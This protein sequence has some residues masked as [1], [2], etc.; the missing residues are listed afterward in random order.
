[1][2]AKHRMSLFGIFLIVLMSLSDMSIFAATRTFDGGP[3]GT[4][5]E[6][7]TAAN[8]SSDTKPTST[9]DAVI[10]VGFTVQVDEDANVNNLT[11]AGVLEPNGSSSRVMT[12]ERDLTVSAGGEIHYTDSD[13][14]SST[15]RM[16]WVFNGV[17][18]GTN[19][20]NNT[21]GASSDLQFYN[22]T[23]DGDMITTATKGSFYIYGSFTS[24]G[25]NF[26][27]ADGDGIIYF[28]EDA[29]STSQTITP[30][31]ANFT[32]DD[33]Y[34]TGTT[35]SLETNEEINV[36]GN[37]NVA[38]GNSFV[39]TGAALKI[40]AS[41]ASS[42]ITPD[43]TLTFAT[44]S[45]LDIDDACV[46]AGNLP[47]FAGTVDIAASKTFTVAPNY[48]ISGTGSL[49]TAAAS[50]IEIEDGDGVAGVF[51]L[52]GSHSI[53]DAT[54]YIIANGSLGFS[55]LS[56][57]KIDDLYIGDDD[58]DDETVTGTESFT[59]TGGLIIMD[60]ASSGNEFT[61][62]SGTITMSGTSKTI[63]SNG[64]TIDIYALDIA[65]SITS[66]NTTLLTI[67]NFLGTSGSGTFTMDYSAGAT[68]I[69]TFDADATM[70]DRSAS[71][72]SA[73]SIAIGDNNTIV[74]TGTL[75]LASDLYLYQ[76]TTGGISVSAAGVLDFQ[77]NSIEF[78]NHA[79]F[80]TAAAATLKTSI[81]GGF[82]AN[83]L[84]TT[85]SANSVL[86]IDNATDYVYNSGATDLG[87]ELA[88]G[89][90]GAR[91]DITT[92]DDITID[93]AVIIGDY[94][95][96]GTSTLSSSGNFT[97]TSGTFTPTVASDDVLD[98]TGAK[99][100]TNSA[101]SAHDL[102]FGKVL[103]SGTIET[104]GD[105]HF[106]S[107]LADALDVT[108]TLNAN[109]NDSH[110]YFDGAGGV[111]SI[112]GNGGTINFHDLTIS[113]GNAAIDATMT[114]MQ[115]EGDL[116][117]SGTGNLTGAAASDVD[118]SGATAQTI[119]IGANA[120]SLDIVTVS[121]TSGGVTTDDDMT[122]GN[123]AGLVTLSGAGGFIQT[124]GTVTKA[125]TG[126][127]V[128][129]SATF[130]ILSIA[131]ATTV[132]GDHS[133]RKELRGAGT[134]NQTGGTVTFL[135]DATDLDGD[136]D[137]GADGKKQCSVDLSADGLT[138]QPNGVTVPSDVE[139]KISVATA[140]TNTVNFSVDGR[141]ELDAATSV[142][143][144]TGGAMA[145]N[146]GSD[147]H[148]SAGASGMGTLIA[149][150]GTVTLDS[151]ASIIF[152]GTMTDLEMGT[153]PPAYAGTGGSGAAAAG[154]VD[155]IRNIT[156]NA[157]AI[158][159]TADESMTVN[160]NVKNLSVTD[161]GAATAGTFT[162]GG[163]A[164]VTNTGGGDFDF[165]ALEV[166]GTATNSADNINITGT[167]DGGLSVMSGGSLTA[168]SGTIT[169][170]DDD[171]AA[172]INIAN[173]ASAASDFTAH[174]LAFAAGATN[175]NFNSAIT[176]A[177]SLYLNAAATVAGGTS[178]SVAFTGN[179]ETIST[180]ANSG[181]TLQDVSVE[182]GVVVQG[183]FTSVVAG[184]FTVTSI[185]DFSMTEGEIQFVENNSGTQ[186][187]TNNGSLQFHD[188]E[189][190]SSAA[191]Y[192]LVGD[193]MTV[194]GNFVI[195]QGR[196]Q[197]DAD[198]T[199]TLDG[200][201]SLDNADNDELDLQLENVV[202]S[203]GT[204]TL[205]DDA[206]VK[207]NFTVNSGGTFATG[208]TTDIIHMDSTGTKTIIN[209]GTLTFG[210]LTIGDMTSNVVTT[211]SDFT[212]SGDMVVGGS[213]NTGE[214]FT[215]TSGVITF[216]GA[217]GLINNQT[218]T[219]VN[220]TLNS[221]TVPTGDHLNVEG[222]ASEQYYIN[223]DL[224]VAG[225]GVF[226]GLNAG[227]SK[228]WFGGAAEQTIS[229]GSAATPMFVYD[230]TLNNANGIKLTSTNTNIAE[231]QFDVANIL[232]LQN[233]DI[234]LNGNNIIT[235]DY[236]AN[237]TSKLNETDGNTVK[238]SG[239]SS[240][241]GH[242]V[243]KRTYA[244]ATSNSN[245]A[246]LGARITATANPG[247]VTVKRYHT[248][249]TIGGDVQASRYYGITSANGS[250]SGKLV[251]E[252]D[253]SELGA[254][255]ESN[256]I[257]LRSTDETNGP[258]Y[259]QTAT[260]NT[261]LNRLSTESNTITQFTGD[262]EFWT[263]GTPDVVSATQLTD[264]LADNPLAS[265]SDGNTIFGVQFTS[266]GAVEITD[267]RFNL[268]R[269]LG[270]T[271][272][273][274]D[275]EIFYS[276][277]SDPATTGDN[278]TL[279][280]GTAATA[281]ISG[282]ST[283][284][285]YVE[286]DLDGQ[287]VGSAYVTVN[288]GSPVNYFLR[289][290]PIE[291]LTA[292]TST[293]TPAMTEAQVTVTNGV[294]EPFTL[295]GTIYSFLP[296]IEV[297][298]NFIG[299]SQGPLVV[300]QDDVPIWG[301]KAELTSTTGL[302]GYTGFTLKF[303][304]DP[305]AVFD[306]VKFYVSTD[307]DFSTTADNT[308]IT[309]TT[310]TIGSSS[311]VFGFAERKLNGSG[312][313]KYYFVTADVKSTIDQ[314]VSDI[315]PRMVFADIT[316]TNAGIRGTDIDGSAL[317]SVVGYTYDF[318]NSRVTASTDYNP[319]ASNLGRNF[320]KQPI[321]NFTLTP[322]D[323]QSV[324]FTKVI[325]HVSLSN[326]YFVD[327]ANWELFNDANNDGYGVTSERVALGTL[328]ST[329]TK[330]NLTFNMIAT[331]TITSATN[332]I[333]AVKPK[334]TASVGGTIGVYIPDENYIYVS[335]PAKVNS[336]GPFP[337]TTVTHTIRNNGTATKLEFVPGYDSTVVSGSTLSFVAR[338]IDAS[339]YPT[340]VSGATNLTLTKVSGTGTLGGTATGTIA[341]GESTVAIAPSFS[342]ASTNLLFNIVDDAAGLTSSDNSSS[343]TIYGAAPAT[344]NGSIT[345]DAATAT[346]I[347][348]SR[349]IAATPTSGAK[350]IVV[351]RQGFSPADPVNGVD[352][353][354]STDIG[355]AGDVGTGQTAAGSYVI[356]D[357]TSNGAISITVRGLVPDTR[358][359]FKIF[360]Y[361]GSG[362]TTSYITSSAFTSESN[363]NPTSKKTTT[364]S[365]SSIS[366]STTAANIPTDVDVTS[367]I[368]DSLDVDF[369][370]FRV[371]NS[372]NNI[373][374]R[375]S[376]LTADCRVELYDNSGNNPATMSL[377][378]TTNISSTS[379]EVLILNGLTNGPYILRIYAAE[380]DNFTT[381][382]YT[383]RVS[384]SANEIMSVTN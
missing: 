350:R 358:Y 77:A 28:N 122:F 191:D 265:G 51:N 127:L 160:G 289:V 64:E 72:E 382:S 239:L 168:S 242:A 102:K 107:T 23:L 25:G 176:I 274:S 179:S 283:G 131:A 74:V 106:A 279:L 255:S 318:F 142:I 121:N 241:T 91:A 186:T 118:F 130:N 290:D 339:G 319:A 334:S 244:A 223:G 331:E 369:F 257:M 377:L 268:G 246:G 236:D 85:A 323:G 147:L 163:V 296:S 177:G 329:A 311:I 65:G 368:S 229:L 99:T 138:F 151:A 278:V 333:I 155:V 198:N 94:L 29:S 83:L 309:L 284:D 379:D 374:I 364:G 293:I 75:T 103:V 180:E 188:F 310:E 325:T 326:A 315:T 285:S 34:L 197:A 228:I 341:S 105:F 260:L 373:L 282:A 33:L 330:G 202:I 128:T 361:N 170:V 365:F 351:M 252:Y 302:P 235:F 165:W 172:L 288:Q 82:A 264:N 210:G 80:T 44:G 76:A 295:N 41:A 164:D 132:T 48:E 69:L 200:T 47:S 1:M 144:T 383:L 66:D 109:T 205:G 139:L 189:M 314:S 161:F 125:S 233:G 19:F 227:T 277:D 31:G 113:G 231:D 133:I 281:G 234:D 299:V 245:L 56:I 153:M 58:T 129:G 183:D 49:T 367:T 362:A 61:T 11:V 70:Y 248:Q 156:F 209:N 134:Y 243:G 375:I 211:T 26:T 232:R 135:G 36:L 316:S 237:P 42:T 78:N 226:D 345:L 96:G 305:S 14:G 271:V 220:F 192:L 275:F 214:S 194:N 86:T 217:P 185:G 250:L 357:G 3:G 38:S 84:T 173:N 328:D 116:T 292:S 93:G 343:I 101:A 184:D 335:S 193:D 321:F 317:D 380:R 352:Y 347:P 79:D 52:S 190:N 207:G 270:A 178:S 384:T 262:N 20:I 238:N 216:T 73:A 301:F 46:L 21:G 201:G 203:G 224:T 152:T 253:E 313:P 206:Q 150:T 55:G 22:V 167:G 182:G 68:N 280:S 13:L 87:F 24:T 114:D 27:A 346:T 381:A 15:G 222:G 4:G 337:A 204:R 98:F 272:D 157:G 287:S 141:L 162:L 300:G 353:T 171:G 148:I 88:G 136:A 269:A 249:R 123:N 355:S 97:L 30:N 57:T 297:T 67:N 159:L 108:G 81:G 110:I 6:W 37:L 308:E 2:K 259:K 240:S 356:Y 304:N 306:N 370:K 7:Q 5:T 258:W 354:A 18:G 215:A 199:I 9:D 322:D 230:M 254:L 117:L 298:E 225:T 212:V 169:L 16:S 221:V 154:K 140:A 45:T 63:T 92:V 119:E 286:F 62:N 8:W 187:I 100:I 120:L 320:A 251:M 104:S 71:S 273:F 115:I 266:N 360:E 342:T 327:F 137:T 43:G 376:D 261:S 372:K 175:V 54:D 208:A 39:V 348:I 50:G 349:I 126:N 366:D 263:L 166:Y 174:D 340:T 40:G 89:N 95:D 267:V 344:N 59:M 124:A 32:F 336:G 219:A 291:S 112:D 35:S 90:G 247:L 158:A 338:A 181:L 378:R 256:L 12:I 111:V 371:P 149:G 146:A 359:Y 332:Y 363:K 196:F 276:A 324:D 143:T 294:V 53:D 60:D 218:G 307:A 213:T 303:D 17:D 195:T 10:P 145:F 312:S